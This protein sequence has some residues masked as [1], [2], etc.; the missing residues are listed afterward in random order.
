MDSYTIGAECIGGIYAIHRGGDWFVRVGFNPN[1]EVPVSRRR[2]ESIKYFM[3]AL[4]RRA[5]GDTNYIDLLDR[6]EVV[7]VKQAKDALDEVEVGGLALF[8]LDW[9]PKSGRLVDSRGPTALV[10]VA[11][12]GNGDENRLQYL[13]NSFDEVVKGGRT[14]KVNHEFKQAAGVE[15]C[16]PGVGWFGEPQALIRMLPRSSFRMKQSHPLS[17]GW[18]ELVLHWT[19]RELKPRFFRRHPRQ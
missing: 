3:G 6:D 13:A 15:V 5:G 8:N 12:C 7:T 17:T 2:R 16:A 1:T 11:V 14:V 18:H 4:E 10:L 19:G 9:D